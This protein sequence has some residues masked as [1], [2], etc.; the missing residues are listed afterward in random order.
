[1]DSLAEA[2]M[3]LQKEEESVRGSLQ[4]SGREQVLWGNLWSPN[5]VPISCWGTVPKEVPR[6]VVR[7]PWHHEINSMGSG[8]GAWWTVLC[9]C[10]HQYPGAGTLLPSSLRPWTQDHWTAG[11]SF[12]LSVTEA[13]AAGC[14]AC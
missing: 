3:W 13:A 11:R 5:T 14:K 2:L 10:G 4:S 7:W 9:R 12:L 1:M 8:L 6:F